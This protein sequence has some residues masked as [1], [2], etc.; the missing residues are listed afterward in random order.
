MKKKV[1]SIVLAIALV[2]CMIPMNA[3]FADASDDYHNAI[4]SAKDYIT[5]N[6]GSLMPNVSEYNIVV[7]NYF[8][9]LNDMHSQ[10]GI[11][12]IYDVYDL[13]DIAEANIIAKYESLLKYEYYVIEAPTIDADGRYN[14]RS[15]Y[16]N[17][18]AV[19]VVVNGKLLGRDGC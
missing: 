11:K 18:N 3:V 9:A 16:I 5:D 7:T 8:N 13:T 15:Y 10:E 17:D 12:N 6:Y 19:K 1:F 4:E 14:Q 2:V